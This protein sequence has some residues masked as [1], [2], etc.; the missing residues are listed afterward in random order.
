MAG[1]LPHQTPCPSAPRRLA[2]PSKWAASLRW[3]SRPWCLPARCDGVL[4]VSPFPP[5]PKAFQTARWR[6]AACVRGASHWAGGLHGCLNSIAPRHPHLAWSSACREGLPLVAVVAPNHVKKTGKP[7]VWKHNLHVAC[8]RVGRTF[9]CVHALRCVRTCMNLRSIRA[10]LLLCTF[11][12]C[13]SDHKPFVQHAFPLFL[14]SPHFLLLH[15]T[16]FGLCCAKWHSMFILPE[17]H[18]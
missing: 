17:G 5:H 9:P 18:C 14:A 3:W 8:T 2:P 11:T 12:G 7:R 4:D 16:S 15:T 6:L 13:F 1:T 10:V